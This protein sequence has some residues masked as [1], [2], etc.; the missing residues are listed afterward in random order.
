MSRYQQT[1]EEVIKNINGPENSYQ[2][3]IYT[4]LIKHLLEIYIGPLIFLVPDF[5]S[6][7]FSG[8]T[9]VFNSSVR[10]FI[11]SFVRSLGRFWANGPSFFRE[12][13]PQVAS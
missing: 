11:G 8:W 4:A 1:I 13:V 7:H 3:I 5:W 2:K 9:F 12:I 10:T 6:P